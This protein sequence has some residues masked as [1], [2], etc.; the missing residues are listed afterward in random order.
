MFNS[1]YYVYGND[2][3]VPAHLNFGKYMLDRLRTKKDEIALEHMDTNEKLS[4]KEFT[5]YAVN[6]SASLTRLGVRRGDT[7]AVGSEK[8]NEFVPTAL[9]IV[10][11]G[12][13]YTP[14]ELKSGRAGLKLK[15]NITQPKFLICS[16]NFWELHKDILQGFE[17]IKQI[18]TLDDPFDSIP[19]TRNLVAQN[20]DVELF[21]PETVLGQT[22]V[23]FILYSSGTTGLSKGVQLTH[24]NCILNSLPYDFS[25][26]SVKTGLVFGEWYHN[27]DIFMTCKFLALGKKIVYAED[28]NTE[29]ILRSVHQYK[30]NVVFAVPSLVSFLSKEG[31]LDEHN[32]DSL[33]IIYS[34]SSPL[35]K[36]TIKKVKQRFPSLKNI[37]QGYGM[38]EAGEL[39]SESWGNKGSKPGSVGKAS[40]G[41]TIKVSDLESRK[42]VGPNER[43]EICLKGPVL[44]KGYV[45]M[46][47]SNYTDDEG[48]FRT[49]DLGYYDEDE[50]F[51]IVGR[52]KEI[53][54]YDGYKIPPLELETLLQMH[55]GVKEASVVGQPIPVLGELPTAFIVRQP[56]FNVSEKELLDYIAEEVSLTKRFQDYLQTL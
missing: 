24:L 33:K 25:D 48:F 53:I 35:H 29:S 10:F 34:R 45:G 55:P 9:A 41:I 37:L 23:A 54:V 3:Q 6:L 36:T 28:V 22:D 20:V 31:D 4:Y 5:Q 50:Y 16:K 47:L 42:T 26:I 39:T 18:M 17:C 21:E 14:Y 43:G 46:D 30:T 15:L 32:L 8:R 7:V 44:M 2:V 12:A 49:G 51:Y 38:T 19:S 52:L 27:Y 40:P 13:I 56:G 1:K 11:T